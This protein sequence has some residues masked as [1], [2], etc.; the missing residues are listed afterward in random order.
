MDRDS[1][2]KRIWNNYLAHFVTHDVKLSLHPWRT[3][4]CQGL[5]LTIEERIIPPS[6]GNVTMQNTLLWNGAKR[7]VPGA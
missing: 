6:P 3:R 4:Y 1:R 2:E 7:I 5:I